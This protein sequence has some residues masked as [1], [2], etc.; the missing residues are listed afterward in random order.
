MLRNRPCLIILLKCASSPQLYCMFNANE[1]LVAER[2]AIGR[3]LQSG[4]RKRSSKIKKFDR[5]DL[6]G[7]H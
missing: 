5:S 2:C 7:A 6:Q 4:S 1:Y 3:K